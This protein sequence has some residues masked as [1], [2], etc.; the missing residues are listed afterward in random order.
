MEAMVTPFNRSYFGWGNNQNSLEF[1]MIGICALIGYSIISFT[2]KEIEIEN[3]RRRRVPVRITFGIGII[4]CY[5]VSIINAIV[6]S[7]AQFRATWLY[8]S[9]FISIIIFCICLVK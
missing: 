9:I 8:A 3:S 1:M 4:G 7:L 5:L 2:S 6:I